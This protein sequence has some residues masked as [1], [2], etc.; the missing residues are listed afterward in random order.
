MQNAMD[1]GDDEHRNESG[2]H[3]YA[4]SLRVISDTLALADISRV[5]GAP[6][7]SHDI[8]DPVGRGETRRRQ[9]YWGLTAD[10]DKTTPLE[11]H[12]EQIVE[13]AEQHASGLDRLRPDCRLIDIICSVHAE[14]YAEGGWEFPPALLRRLA[15]LDLTLG[16]FVS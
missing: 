15:D 1:L 5:L 7:D 3:E 13:F 14:P 4:A 9:A 6:T 10:V 2:K 8:G 16:A 12:V 11:S